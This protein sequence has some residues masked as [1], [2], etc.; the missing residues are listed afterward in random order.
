MCDRNIL[1]Y[2]HGT[3][4]LVRQVIWGIEPIDGSVYYFTED[5]DTLIDDGKPPDAGPYTQIGPAI[6]IGDRT[7]VI[8]KVVVMKGTPDD[9]NKWMS[10]EA[11][12]EAKKARMER[13]PDW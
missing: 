2:E 4:D 7:E 12:R 11:K 8:C 10:R 1:F 6:Y 3:G 5:L 13:G 9:R